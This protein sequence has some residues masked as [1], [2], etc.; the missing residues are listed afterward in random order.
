[1]MFWLREQ[2]A[3]KQIAN[4]LM[5]M[6]LILCLRYYDVVPLKGY[7]G[8]QLPSVNQRSV[9]VMAPDGDIEV[10]LVKRDL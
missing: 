3:G 5:K 7:D 8:L 9:S 2:C 4:Y 10:L 6:L 1:M